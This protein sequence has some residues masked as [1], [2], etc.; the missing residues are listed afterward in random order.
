MYQ[1]ELPRE[2]NIFIHTGQAGK[3]SHAEGGFVEPVFT[4]HG[5]PG[6]C[7]PAIAPLA[8]STRDALP[9][10]AL[11]WICRSTNGRRPASP[12][13]LGQA[14]V[15][16]G[17]VGGPPGHTAWE[18]HEGLG[19]PCFSTT[20]PR[21]CLGSMAQRRPPGNLNVTGFSPQTCFGLKPATPSC[22]TCPRRLQVHYRQ[23][24]LR[25]ESHLQGDG[26]LST[27]INPV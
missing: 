9:G 15:E 18:R 2:S 25:N 23:E 22:L 12:E 27:F 4:A 1:P 7:H 20:S 19:V 11:P 3:D 16:E 13:K 6:L 10:P 17:N 26:G 24:K 5:R 14:T 21:V 8:V